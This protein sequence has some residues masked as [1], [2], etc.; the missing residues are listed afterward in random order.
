MMDISTMDGY[1]FESFIAT[2]LR[3]MGL[4]VEET[5][6][7]GDGG[8]DLIA[9]YD[10]PILKGV[11]LVQCKL[12]K[13]VIGEPAVR[14]LYGVVLSNKRASKGILITNSDFSYQANKF[15]EDKNIEL[16]NGTILNELINKYMLDESKIISNKTDSKKYFTSKTNFDI[17]KYS[18]YR[19]QRDNAKQNIENHIN[20]FNN[21]YTYVLK[22][23]Y[24]IM[25]SGLLIELLNVLNEAIRRFSKKGEIDRRIE[26]FPVFRGIVLLLL[27]RVDEA[28]KNLIEQKKINE[29][30]EFGFTFYPH[31]YS[32]KNQFYWEFYE[33]ETAVETDINNFFYLQEDTNLYMTYKANLITFMIHLNDV[34]NAKL[35][36]DIVLKSYEKTHKH[37]ESMYPGDID[38][39]NKYD[40]ALV[41]EDIKT[42][43][44]KKKDYL[45]IPFK[46]TFKH[47]SLYVSSINKYLSIDKIKEYLGDIDYEE[48]KKKISLYCRL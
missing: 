33:R 23:D 42:A 27:G 9:S 6:L 35:L 24:D 13:G 31:C 48:Q 41:E 44:E 12:W 2:M 17:D 43:F 47:N 45:F 3:N 25:Y 18:F 1:Q 40:L 15:A 8:V 20:L 4:S 14:D 34:E 37:F 16:I 19:S 30:L 32:F 38:R 28:L 5:K 22:A 36:L 10:Y 46:L 7:S 11:F 26:V 21:L 39:Y 29:K